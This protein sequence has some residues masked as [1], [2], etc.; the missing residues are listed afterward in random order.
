MSARAAVLKFSTE[1]RVFA[2]VLGGKPASTFPGH[3]LARNSEHEP[4]DL[5]LPARD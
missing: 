4:L 2:H 5:P 1:L 3:A